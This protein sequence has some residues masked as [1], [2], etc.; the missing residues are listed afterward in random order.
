MQEHAARHV[1]RRRPRIAPFNER[2]S[3]DLVRERRARFDL[4]SDEALILLMGAGPHVRADGTRPV[5][6]WIV[7]GTRVLWIRGN[8][9]RYEEVA[10]PLARPPARGRNSARYHVC[11]RCAARWYSATLSTLTGCAQTTPLVPPA[12]APGRRGCVFE[13]PHITASAHVYHVSTTCGSCPLR[14]QSPS[15]SSPALRFTEKRRQTKKLPGTSVSSTSVSHRSSFSL[16]LRK[17]SLVPPGPHFS[18]LHPRKPNEERKTSQ[19]AELSTLY[20]NS[21][22]IPRRSPPV[23]RHGIPRKATG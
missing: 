19:L 1:R 21:N 11:W 14:R 18:S 7:S 22:E 15:G 3:D 13:I 8:G 20:R 5:A 2:S 4:R 10:F 12:A 23:A 9:A 16:S 6:N 17:T